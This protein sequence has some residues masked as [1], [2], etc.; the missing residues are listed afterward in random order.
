MNTE[1]LGAFVLGEST[2]DSVRL[3]DFE[4]VI[5]TPFEHWARPADLLCLVDAVLPGWSP[6]VRGWK[7]VVL[8]MP[9]QA[10]ASCQS[11]CVS[12]GPGSRLVSAIV[13]RVLSGKRLSGSA[14]DGRDDA[15]S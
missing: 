14:G 4:G 12:W 13:G 2:P 6:L 8:A 10:A 11:H 5:Q 15:L 3:R 9:R 7:N 1:S